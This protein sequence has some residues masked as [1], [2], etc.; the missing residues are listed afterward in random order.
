ME[1]KLDKQTAQ[2]QIQVLDV[3]TLISE[4]PPKNDF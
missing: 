1:T 3:K 2:S 4:N